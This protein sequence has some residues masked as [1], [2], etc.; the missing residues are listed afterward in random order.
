[1]IHVCDRRCAGQ[2]FID[3]RALQSMHTSARHRERLDGPERITIGRANF[4]CLPLLSNEFSFYT[5]ER[6]WTL[7]R[8]ST[9]IRLR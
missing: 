7:Q 3:L 6:E 2:L 8:Q 9:Q 5:C 4:N 1:M